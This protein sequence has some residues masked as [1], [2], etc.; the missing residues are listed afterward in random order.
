MHHI[1]S[2]IN[3]A[4]KKNKGE[5]VDSSN[6][7]SSFAYGKSKYTSSEFPGSSHL[8][9]LGIGGDHV[10]KSGPLELRFLA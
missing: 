4:A 3:A 7:W 10:M 8:K 1:N 6:I 9:V 5:K 2:H